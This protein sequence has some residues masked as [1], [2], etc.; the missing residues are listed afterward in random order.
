M[1]QRIKYFYLIL[2]IILCCW[3]NDFAPNIILRLLY[4]FALVCPL[5]FIKE[6]RKY[7]PYV[8]LTFTAISAYGF[9]SSFLPT[10]TFYYT[11][12]LA[13]IASIDKNTH[14]NTS[15]A[16]IIILYAIYI[17]IVDLISNSKVENISYSAFAIICAMLCINTTERAVEK[18]FS[19]SFAIITIILCF[20]FFAFGNRFVQTGS[21]ER[22]FWKDPNY[23]GAVAGIGVV[24][25]YIQIIAKNKAKLYFVT[26][27]LGFTMLA[28]NASRGAALS[29]IT[30]II[31]IT[32][33]SR[34]K[35]RLKFGVIFLGCILLILLYNLH[36]FDILLTRIQEDDGTGNA[37]TIIWAYKLEGYSAGTLFQKL[38]GIGYQNGF[39]LGTQDGYGFH[40]DYLAHLI[41]YGIIGIT[42]FIILLLYPIYVCWPN[43]SYRTSVIAYI[44]YLAICCLTIEPISAGRITYFFLYLF[45]LTLAKYARHQ[46]KLSK[47]SRER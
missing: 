26:F 22:V 18:Y 9:S 20:Y 40:N 28:L 17:T 27:L 39:M 36:I 13:I 10:E 1:P 8:I 43:K 5:I 24:S 32:L 15:K 46:Y 19:L 4:L 30:A 2:I 31:I 29:T 11:A 25:S 37:R 23:L 38:F 3:T 35:I 42:L 34:I 21:L 12:I 7:A 33:F 14:K 6:V 44:G 16:P 45:A 41:D 47:S